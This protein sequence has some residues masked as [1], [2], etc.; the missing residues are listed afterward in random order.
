MT[1]GRAGEWYFPDGTTVPIEG[2]GENGATTFYRNRG[3]DGSVNLN[4]LNS[5]VMSPTGLFCCEVPDAND[6]NKTVCIN[7]GG[8]ICNYHCA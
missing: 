7:I 5:D 3:D 8:F 4:R 2:E 6:I 1:N